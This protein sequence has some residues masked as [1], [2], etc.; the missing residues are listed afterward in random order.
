MMGRLRRLQAVARGA[1][2]RRAVRDGVDVLFFASWWMDEN[3]TRSATLEAKARGLSVAVAVPPAPRARE[4]DAVRAYAAAGVQ[5]LSPV[6]AE[7]VRAIPAR[8]VVTATNGLRPDGFHPAVRRFVHMPHS[9]VSLHMIY[10]GDSFDGYDTLFACGEHQV[11]EFERLSELRGLPG[12]S[13]PAV[14][15]GKLDLLGPR[16]AP[17]EPR[18]VLIGPSWGEQN[19]LNTIG[20]DLVEGLLALG[21]RVTVRPHP[22]FE[23]TGNA[24][25]VAMRERFA[26]RDGFT[27][28]SPFDG[29]RALLR[30]GVL[31]T[32][33][34]GIAFEYATLRRRR[35]VFV[36]VAKK[37]LNPAWPELGLEPVE[38]GLRAALGPVVSPDAAQALEA[39]LA[40]ASDEGPDLAVEATLPKFIVNPGACGAAAART[41][42]SLVAA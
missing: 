7:V 42:A 8:V 3:W 19:I 30:A 4:R 26:G 39:V 33:Y 18:H 37:V 13:A 16:L 1:W 40:C 20:P 32:D 35:C 25:W 17:L 23:Q 14:G 29:D 38:I 41:L 12:R 34:S 6:E 31:V 22:M 27:A 9:L 15:Y 10:A 36:D 24:A 5:V 28:E 2:Q 11:R 21:C